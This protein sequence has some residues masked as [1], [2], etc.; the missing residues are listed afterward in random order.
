VFLYGTSEAG[1]S[2]PVGLD[3]GRFLISDEAAGPEVT[4]GRDFR[5]L[6]QKLDAVPAS[7][8]ARLNSS[9]PV[10][11][12]GLDDFKKIVRDRAAAHAG[13]GK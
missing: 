3:Q 12:L 1:F 5:D 6:A 11:R 9:S 8:Q 10:K 13:G 4:N 7:A 2:S